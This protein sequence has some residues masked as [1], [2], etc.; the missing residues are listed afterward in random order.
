ML[1]RHQAD[2]NSVIPESTV[3]TAAGEALKSNPDL[4]GTYT[5][6]TNAFDNQMAK[7]QRQGCNNDQTGRFTPLLIRITTK[8]TCN[9]G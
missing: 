7:H 5:A 9:P 3:F 6:G 1:G 4:N 8:S 2:P